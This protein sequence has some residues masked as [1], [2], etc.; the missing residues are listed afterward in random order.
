MPIN[1]LC[2]GARYNTEKW[3]G[4]FSCRNPTSIPEF[5]VSYTHRL[6]DMGHVSVEMDRIHVGGS[7]GHPV[8]I[9]NDRIELDVLS[10]PSDFRIRQKAGEF[11][12]N[13][14]E[15]KV[16]VRFRAENR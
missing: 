16:P 3:A 14:S 5:N 7:N 15:R 6:K 11:F 8:A 1:V 12:S 10:D 2:L 13:G 4:Q 9:K